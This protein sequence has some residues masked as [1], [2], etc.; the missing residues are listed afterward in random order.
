[1]WLALE[2]KKFRPADSEVVLAIYSFDSFCWG[3]TTS[4]RSLECQTGISVT[5]LDSLS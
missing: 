2:E 5:V 4:S 1:M 3:F